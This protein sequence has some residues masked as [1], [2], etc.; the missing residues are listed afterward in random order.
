[1]D[2]QSQPQPP[3]KQA[4]CTRVKL[5]AEA[6]DIV[7]RAAALA[8][9]R[10]PAAVVDLLIR[11]NRGVLSDSAAM[12]RFFSEPRPRARRKYHRWK[13]SGNLNGRGTCEVCGMRRAPLRVTDD[14]SS[15]DDRR[16]LVRGQPDWI[17][18]RTVPPCEPREDP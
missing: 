3:R 9:V 14:V 2:T 8:G 15:S 5:T 17:I 13:W 11:A 4:A 12:E 7:R 1:M 10:D 16:Y 6:T 18:S